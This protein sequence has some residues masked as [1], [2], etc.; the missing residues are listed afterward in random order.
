MKININLKM[1]KNVF[2]FTLIIIILLFLAILSTYGE[3][4]IEYKKVINQEPCECN[5]YFEEKEEINWT[6]R[7]FNFSFINPIVFTNLTNCE[8]IGCW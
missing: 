8:P 3:P 7:E 5:C 2:W 4:L 6:F 1:D